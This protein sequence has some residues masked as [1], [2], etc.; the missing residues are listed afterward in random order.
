MA[1]QIIRGPD[2]KPAFAVL[3]WDEYRALAPDAADSALSNEEL[4]DRA[5]TEGDETFP[6][7]VADRLIA[8]NRRSRSSVNIEA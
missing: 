3:P 6:A 7:E 4:F 1:T 5:K 2:G 8:G